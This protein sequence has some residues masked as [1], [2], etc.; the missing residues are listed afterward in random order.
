[1]ML[2][3]DSAQGIIKVGSPPKKLP[4]ILES[5]EVGGSLIVENAQMQGQSG[6]TR[7]VHG[8]NDSDVSITI[9]LIDDTARK[10]TRFDLLAEI[11]TVFKTVSS[12]GSPEVFTLSHPMTNAWGIK[13]L[14]F[15]D[16]KTS[17]SRGRKKVSVKLEFKEHEIT[18]GVSQERKDAAAR[19]TTQTSAASKEAIAVPDSAARRLAQKEKQ[20]GYI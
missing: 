14:L 7:T 5:I 1:M 2:S 4:G 11:V 18:V 8:W 20:L 9:S 16:L 19:A 15:S 12:S 17:E 10:K 13:K 6:T 3:V